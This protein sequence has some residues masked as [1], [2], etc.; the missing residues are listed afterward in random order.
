MKRKQC[1]LQLADPWHTGDEMSQQNLS[2]ALFLSDN[3]FSSTNGRS[4]DV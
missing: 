4:T 1:L 3:R 2:L